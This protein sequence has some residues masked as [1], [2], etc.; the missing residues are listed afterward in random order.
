MNEKYLTDDVL[1]LFDEIVEDMPN[2]GGQ[3]VLVGGN[4]CFTDADRGRLTNLKKAGMVVTDHDPDE[5]ESYIRLTPEGLQLAEDR[6]LDLDT[7]PMWEVETR[8]QEGDW[9]M[10]KLRAPDRGTA[11]TRVVRRGEELLKIRPVDG[12]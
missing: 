12:F 11:T 9:S 7:F 8:T 10:Y 3:E 4:V 5:D 1:A 2:W 6:K